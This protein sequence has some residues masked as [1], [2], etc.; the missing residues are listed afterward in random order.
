LLLI[1]PLCWQF[2]HL[3]VLRGLVGISPS[4][5]TGARY[6]D[7]GLLL[8][9]L[10]V[11]GGG[12]A[13]LPPA[14]ELIAVMPLL[15]LQGVILSYGGTLLWYQAITRLDLARSTAIV[16]PSIPLLSL[17]ASFVLLG[18]VPSASQWIGLLLT[19]AGVLVFVTAPH[20]VEERERVP[21]ATAP[22]A[23]PGEKTEAEG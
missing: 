2:S 19:A 20:A 21:T 4:V 22:I 15:A 8:V 12:L 23:V 1:T 10:W 13:S 17:A 5:L 11:A 18:E 16:V 9:V 6:I 14:H 7:G 3:I